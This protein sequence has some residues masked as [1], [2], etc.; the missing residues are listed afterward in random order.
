MVLSFMNEEPLY[1]MFQVK[2]GA[3]TRRGTSSTGLN[4]QDLYDD[5]GM[6]VGDYIAFGTNNAVATG[7]R[8][9][10]LDIGTALAATGYT[11]VWEYARAN[12]SGSSDVEW[13]AL[14]NVRDDTDG[15][16]NTGVNLVTWDYPEDWN[17]HIN[18][19]IPEPSGS[20]DWYRWYVR[21]RITG[22]TSLTEGGRLGST[23]GKIIH[24]AI[25]AV[26]GDAFSCQDIYD[27]DQ[28]GTVTLHSRTGL[29]G[30]DATAEKFKFTS[31]LGDNNIGG[32]V[33]NDLYI[34][35]ANYSGFTDATIQISGL[36]PAGNA[37]T[38]YVVVTANGTTY[39]AK[40]WQQITDSQITTVTGTGS[41][42]YDV[43][44]GRWGV[45][46]QQGEGQFYFECA[47]KFE[48]GSTWQETQSNILMK[49]AMQPVNNCALE[50]GELINGFPA[51]GVSFILDGHNQDYSGG[52]L[53]GPNSKVY[54]TVI[55]HR[56]MD[57]ADKH[58]GSW[59]GGVA[60]D[61]G[62]DF[63]GLHVDRYRNAAYSG[64]STGIKDCTAWS[65][66]NESKGA[67]AQNMTH[68]GGLCDRAARTDVGEQVHGWDLTGSGSAECVNPWQCDSTQDY[69][70]AFRDCIWPV[71]SVK[72]KDEQVRW[73]NSS[74]AVTNI[75]TWGNPELYERYSVLIKL[76][77][78]DGAVISGAT[79]T[80][81]DTDDNVVGTYT[82]NADGFFGEFNG[83]IDNS[84]PV[85]TVL[86]DS[87]I[88]NDAHNFGRCLITSGDAAG[89]EKM[90]EKDHG[91][92][93]FRFSPAMVQDTA[94]NDRYII[95]PFVDS[96]TFTPVADT[97]N[98]YVDSSVQEHGPFTIK[99][100]ADNY[101]DF[102]F[103]TAIDER[104]EQTIKMSSRTAVN[105]NDGSIVIKPNESY[106]VAG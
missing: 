71:E 2:N 39:L 13:K 47:T 67:M 36:D 6:A 1:T 38:E 100:T 87:D 4:N 17:N 103:E 5:S 42:D 81:T 29:T 56:R 21:C 89:E 91:T 49:R 51:K 25:K 99:I 23:A 8:G 63:A 32:G 102:E 65:G 34:T 30:T 22:L 15:F 28:A 11:Y 24:W 77:D 19:G 31:Y 82:S 37:Q 48:S 3:I 7:Y 95:V 106:V 78:K 66:Q 101:E 62:Q 76:V 90:I 55:R 18:P 94:Q 43:I 93:S 79:M 92:G 41:L 53:M 104:F 98:V 9:V 83:A 44:Q 33:L 16:Q 70:Q 69:W 85:V 88:V 80:I 20:M 105:A 50:W 52:R 96:R 35:V 46:T 54:N 60:Q 97:N 68:F 74:S 84:S 40:Y 75:A 26:S 72:P 12:G 57:N 58:Q 27:A 10:K 64:V 86:N 73:R 59:G 45:V 14:Q 61:S